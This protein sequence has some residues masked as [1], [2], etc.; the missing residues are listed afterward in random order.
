M[1]TKNPFDMLQSIGEELLG[2]ASQS[3]TA[4]KAIQSA[5][6]L[7]ER[8]DDLQK[9]VRGLENLERRMDELEARLAKVEGGSSKKQVESGE[10]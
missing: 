2:K 10:S 7:K 3:P 1:T 5:M 6:Q 8:V 9:R 4:A